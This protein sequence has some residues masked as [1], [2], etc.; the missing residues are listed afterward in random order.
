MLDKFR[1]LFT[2]ILFFIFISTALIIFTDIR[3]LAQVTFS[4]DEA[5]FLADH[6]GTLIQTFNSAI[7]TACDA[8]FDSTNSAG[9]FPPGALFPGVVYDVTPSHE[10]FNIFGPNFNG[11]S[12]NISKAIGPDNH[13]DT[14]DIIFEI[15]GVFTA[16]VK[17]GCFVLLPEVCMRTVTIGVYG[18]GDTFLGSTQVDAS[19]HFD[20]FVGIESVVPI[21][22][23]SVEGPDLGPDSGFHAVSE[24]VFL[25][26]RLLDVPTLSQLGMISV[27]AGLGLIGL[28]FVIRRKRV[29]A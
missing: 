24:V 15:G 16:A 25:Q 19:S 28:F 20:D 4:D 2:C 7:S 27:F 11:S 6:P 1:H 26:G 5:Q 14:L 22:K 3:A 12:G 17:P 13:T 9:C 8:P 29:T 10:F 18:A 21:V 23:I